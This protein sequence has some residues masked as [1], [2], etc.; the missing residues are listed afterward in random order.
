M[1]LI[2]DKT[3]T[4]PSVEAL[5][6]QAKKLRADLTDISHSKALELVAHQ[7]GARDWNTLAALA[8]RN[9]QPSYGLGERVRG[10]Y[11]G[12]AFVGEIIAAQRMGAE[13]T[14]LTIRFDEPVDVVRFDSFSSLRRQVSATVDGDGKTAARTSDGVPHLQLLAG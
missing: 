3:K 6:A 12:Q 14:K 10:L 2:M 5:K 4:L 11:L 13:R 7:W 9:T 1:G 8:G